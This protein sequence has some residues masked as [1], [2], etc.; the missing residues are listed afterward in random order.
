MGDPNE[1]E[2]RMRKMDA[3]G[4][5]KD[6]ESEKNKDPLTKEQQKRQ[7]SFVIYIPKKLFYISLFICFIALIVTYVPRR[8]F[9]PFDEE[10]PYAALGEEGIKL[11]RKYD[12]NGDDQLSIS[13]YESLFFQMLGNGLNLTEFEYNPEQEIE[14]DDQFVT[15][16]AYFTPLVI[17]TM[18]K[19]LE[20]SYFGNIDS[21]SGLKE[22][23]KLNHEWMNFGVRHFSMF[24]PKERVQQGHI[25]DLYTEERSFMSSIGASHLSSNRFY[26]SKIDDKLIGLYRILSMFHPR[27]FLMIRFPPKGGVALVRAQNNDYI[28]IVF[29]FHAEFQ[30]NEPP[31]NPFWFT[32]AQFTGS[33]IISKDYT[34]ILNFNLY[35]PSDKKLN[36]D[37]EWL[38]GP[39]ENEN[40]EV[41][42]GYM[43]LM[44]A[45]ITAKSRLRRHSHDTEEPIE[46]DDTLQDTVNNIIWTHEIGLDDALQQLE[47]KMYPFKKITYYNFTETI[48]KAQEENKLIHSILLWERFI[49]NWNLVV[50]LKEFEKDSS[51]PEIQKIAAHFMENYKFP[52]MMYVTFPNGT[53]VHKVNA[54]D[55][56]DQGEGFMQN[57]YAAFLKTGIAN[58]EKM[59]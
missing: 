46:T 20:E 29:R 56:M 6:K 16:R 23:T 47:V 40:M 5:Q 2:I 18:T 50:D 45:N 51:Q 4:T 8:Y 26:P 42:I 25:F 1:E 44:T 22:W 10:N 3:Y 17:E 35:V 14:E 39:S 7:R 41:D 9:L 21:L 55:Y 24:F 38:N 30:L 43:P 57:P 52:V 32:P 33:L 48:K 28:E 34:R 54:N 31:H 59:A 19:D 13:E 15:M 49:S 11:F 58:A 27:P 36:V 53:I 12:R 37:M